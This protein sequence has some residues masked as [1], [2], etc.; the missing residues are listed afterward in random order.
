M[1]RENEYVDYFF[2]SK[3]T[4]VVRLRKVFE[5]EIK[6][7]ALGNIL[8]L[9]VV[10]LDSDPQPDGGYPSHVYQASINGAWVEI[11]RDGERVVGRSNLRTTADYVK[12]EV[13]ACA[14]NG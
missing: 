7:L 10:D 13:M 12:G 8:E 2:D 6:T 4:S 1:G 11:T 5:G 3:K 14:I 9:E